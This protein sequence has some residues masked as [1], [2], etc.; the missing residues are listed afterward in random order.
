MKQNL[1][2]LDKGIEINGI[3]VIAIIGP[4]PIIL[5]GYHDTS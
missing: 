1:Q 3:Q 5:H 2:I 4:I